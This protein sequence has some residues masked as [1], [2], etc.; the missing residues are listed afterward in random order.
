MNT[1]KAIHYYCLGNGA[2]KCDS[3]KH[4]KNW[5]TLNQM[6]DSLRK[7]I[8]SQAM[9]VNDDGCLLS[10]RAWYVPA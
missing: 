2:S 10:G 7:A 3:C 8:Q 6:P 4:W 5:Q 9:R 1:E